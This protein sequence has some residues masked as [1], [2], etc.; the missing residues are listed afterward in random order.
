MFLPSIVSPFGV[1]LS[2]I[3]AA[4]SVP[5]EVMEAARMDGASEFRIFRTVALQPY[6]AR[7]GDCLPDP[8][9][10]PSGTTSCRPTVLQD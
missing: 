8:V 10:Q 9:R 4:A 1:Y 6:G 5:D 3:F 7:P 2:R